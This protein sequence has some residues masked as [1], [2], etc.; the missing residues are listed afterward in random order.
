MTS[1][2]HSPINSSRR[3]Q[4]S[5][6]GSRRRDESKRVLLANGRT[7][8]CMDVGQQTRTA[9]ALY[10]CGVV[11][12]KDDLSETYDTYVLTRHGNYSLVP[13][14]ASVVSPH[15]SII[16]KEVRRGHNQRRFASLNRMQIPTLC[17]LTLCMVSTSRT[18]TIQ[19]YTQ[20]ANK[21]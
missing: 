13:M 1:H 8:D 12:F 5:P 16:C 7:T 10:T 14:A 6:L 17:W 19:L 9:T 4:T 3:S 18:V 11:C 15:Q 2:L 20:R 21:R